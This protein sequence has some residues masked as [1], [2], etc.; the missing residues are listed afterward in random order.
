MKLERLSH[1]FAWKDRC[2]TIIDRIWYV[3]AY[4]DSYESFSFPGW[5][6]PELFSNSNRICVEY[7]S[8]N[9]AWIA[10]QAEKN[11]HLNW[12]AV[13]KKFE[14]VC[15]IWSKIKKKALANLI[16]IC[17]EGHCATKHYFPSASVDK[18]YINFPDPWPKLRHAKHRLIQPLFIEQLSR[19]LIP[20]GTFTFVTDDEPYGE[21]TFQ[22]MGKY[23][24]EFSSTHPAPGYYTEDEG[25]GTSYFEELWRKKGRTIRY[26]QFLHN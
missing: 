19:I 20:K 9:G 24:Q 8:G 10:E 14:R 1:P 7:C 5:Q 12:L 4:C 3:P 13:E 6:S 2:V 26:Y 23:P 21:W 22:M 25:Y 18:V 17:G 16:V 15:K 11:P